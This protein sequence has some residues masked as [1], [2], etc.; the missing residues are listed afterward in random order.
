[1]AETTAPK[2]ITFV[3]YDEETDGVAVKHDGETVWTEN[4]LGYLDQ[5]FR[6]YAPL[7]EPVIIQIEG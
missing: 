7:G 5:Y 6:H 4:S 3:I 1:M 2:T